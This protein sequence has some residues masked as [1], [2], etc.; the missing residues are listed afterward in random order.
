M[1][2]TTETLNADKIANIKYL[3]GGVRAQLQHLSYA[4]RRHNFRNRDNPKSQIIIQ[5][6]LKD[7]LNIRYNLPLERAAAV[8]H[9]QAIV[10]AT[11]ILHAWAKAFRVTF[12]TCPLVTD[13]KNSL[14]AIEMAI[15][16]PEDVWAFGGYQILKADNG[17]YDAIVSRNRA[18]SLFSNVL[19]NMSES[20]AAQGSSEIKHIPNWDV[21]LMPGD[22][23][24]PIATEQISNWDP[25]PI[26]MRPPRDTTQPEVKA[27]PKKPAAK[28]MPKGASSSAAGHAS[29]KAKSR[30]T[31]SGVP[32]EWVIQALPFY[33]K[34]EKSKAEDYAGTEIAT[35]YW[36]DSRSEQKQ[37]IFLLSVMQGPMAFAPGISGWAQYLRRVTTYGI[38]AFSQLNTRLVCDESACTIPT[39]EWFRMYHYLAKTQMWTKSGSFLTSAALMVMCGDHD[40]EVANQSDVGQYKKDIRNILGCEIVPEPDKKKPE[41]SLSGQFRHGTTILITDLQFTIATTSGSH[42]F[43][44]GLQDM[45]WD[46]VIVYKIQ[47]MESQSNV[48]KF[49]D[50]ATKVKEYVEANPQLVNLTIHVWLS[51]SFIMNPSPPHVV[52]TDANFHVLVRGSIQEL[53]DVCPRPVFVAVCPDSRFNNVEGRTDEMAKK[54]T[55]ELR[56]WGILVST[57]ENMKAPEGS[58]GKNAIWAAMEKALFRQRVFL[59]CASDRDAVDRLNLGDHPSMFVGT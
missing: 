16:L 10:V 6:S 23:R 45:G 54:L 36:A 29:P 43:V 44:M 17:V 47:D 53:E 32:P 42:N 28:P 52:L 24:E 35:R 41:D 56:D 15:D 12:N 50:T 26:D 58:A 5:D 34:E 59:M 46:N 33:F 39:D 37:P 11:T 51:M 7:W 2:S 8:T 30:P 1:P 14:L 4:L 57:S 22:G 55:A 31:P 21:P 27:M 3:M 18:F 13:V 9:L 38:L 40:V 49:M 19:S 48:V 20:Q 25:D